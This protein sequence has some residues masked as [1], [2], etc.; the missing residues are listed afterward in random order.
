MF[1]CMFLLFMQLLFA[2]A[3]A[4]CDS[5]AVFRL[6]ADDT[7]MLNPRTAF[8][9]TRV[10]PRLTFATPAKQGRIIEAFQIELID[11]ATG[12]AWHSGVVNSSWP[13][14]VF[15]ASTTPLEGGRTYEWTVTAR[16]SDG[17]WTAMSHPARFHV[18]LLDVTDWNGVAWLGSM[19][20]DNMYRTTFKTD[21]AKKVSSATL[22]VCGLGYSTLSVNGKVI[23]EVIL[24]TSPWSRTD[25]LNGFAT[26]DITSMLTANTNAIGVMLGHGWRDLSKFPPKDHQNK[27]DTTPERVLR[28]QVRVVYKGETKALVVTKTGDG[29]WS[30]AP[31]PVTSDSVYDGESYDARLEPKAWDTA[32]YEESSL[33][34]AATKVRVARVKDSFSSFVPSSFVSSLI[35]FSGIFFCASVVIAR[36]RTLPVCV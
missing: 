9:V 30:S 5:Q 32:F 33:F 28:A 29:T 15:D 35:S 24:A 20:G 23:D 1:R 19:G 16:T 17:C 36:I 25:K 10:T 27:T 34:H 7:D 4:V 18:S 14:Y 6:L 11:V 22:Y 8:P 13:S 3:L 31:G 2:S 26:V 12:A 21:P